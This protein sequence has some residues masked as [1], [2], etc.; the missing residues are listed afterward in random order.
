VALGLITLL[1]AALRFTR[2]ADVPPGLHYDE[3]FKGVMARTLLQGGPPQ[4]FFQSNMGEEP[5][6]I[7]LVAAS[8]SLA[9]EEPWAVRLPSALVGTLTIPLA[10]WLG[11]ELWR[12]ARCGRSFPGQEPERQTA[13]VGSPHQVQEEGSDQQAALVGL[14]AAAV[15][16]ILY[17]HLTYSRVGIEPILVPFF[18]TLA[19]A[20]LAHGL[21]SVYHGKASALFFV[22][23]GLAVGGSLYTYKAGYLVPLLALLYLGYSAIVERGFL[24]RQGRGLLLM[25]LV[26]FL[27][28]LPIGLYFATHPADFLHRP[29]SVAVL[30]VVPAA[31]PQG[32]GAAG[33]SWQALA[34]NLPRVLGMFFVK[35]DASPRN[36]L[37]GRPALDPFLALLFLVG[38]GRAVTGF[39][40][41]SLA[42]LPIWLVTMIAPTLVTE[43]AP[44][45]G[46]AIGATPAVAVLCS[47]G[48]LTL[49]QGASRFARRW[50]K[51]AVALLLGLG[52]VFSGFSTV[53]A[54]FQTWGRG[55]D[56]FYAYDEGL[57][58]VAGYANTLPAAEVVYLTPTPHDHYTLQFLMRRPLAS[59]DGRAGLV[60][61]PP[62]RA[63]TVIVL[64]REDEATLPVLEK[65]RPDGKIVW[66]LVD[67]YGLPYAVAYHL[68]AAS[69]GKPSSPLPSFPV[70]ATIGDSVRLLGYSLDG[71]QVRPGDTLYLTLYWQA[72]ASLDQDYTVFTH[73]L[74]GHNPATNGPLWAGHDGQPDGGQY[75]TTSWQ[76]GE[77]ILDVH[78][79]TI[80]ADAPP[81][82]YQFEVGLYL[83]ET[84]ARLPASDAAGNAL[85]ADAVMLG[86]VEVQGKE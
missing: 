51:V 52:L 8:M 38:L 33:G 10:W 13:A 44:H 78:P 48:G 42:L 41:P 75:P 64:L 85:P 80:P 22:L 3:G 82:E 71:D 50:L 84:M 46:R 69:E 58:Q 19:F 2:L 56:V 40:R 81:G 77:V 17:W 18:A 53:Q 49:W 62:G 72:L 31:P 21:R 25:A 16:A 47:L 66:S 43:Y 34:D 70:A 73:L 45:F 4:L 36:N 79:L 1:A 74:G 26:A 59:F 76:P 9:G 30:G 7:Y 20:A 57:V 39:R 29:S 24:R 61:P 23:A 15:L 32:E 60:L 68:S 6:A 63:A 55:P 27:V 86:T 65:A 14:G 28:A 37:P 5:L 35:G 54:Y 83:L 67:R 11:R 12:L